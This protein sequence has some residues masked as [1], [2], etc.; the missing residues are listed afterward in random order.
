MMK[1][2]MM[3]PKNTLMP[4]PAAKPKAKPP[5]KRGKRPAKPKGK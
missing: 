4:P 5:T 3:P 2:P 1:R